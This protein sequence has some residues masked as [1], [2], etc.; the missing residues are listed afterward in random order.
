M[1]AGSAL[2]DV[3]DATFAHEVLAESNTR[4]VVVD[5]WAA[6]CGPCRV[7]GPVI[8]RVAAEHGTDVVLARLNTE[9]NP[10]TALAYRIESIPAV[11]A[12][13]HGRVIA[14]FAGAAPEPQVRAFFQ[15]L[16]PSPADRAASEAREFLR[17]GDIAAAEATFRAALGLQSANPDAIVGLAAIL[18]DRG[19]TGAAEELLERVPVDRRAKALKHRLFLDRFAAD[20]RDEDLQAEAAAHPMD[21]RARYRWG[22]ML[23][24]RQE[25]S[26]A[27]D[28][29]LESVRLDRSFADGA[30]RKAALAVFDILG[31]ESPRTRDYQRRL[32]S[33]LF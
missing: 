30:A 8:E 31:L 20:H 1:T 4:P 5:F 2:R 17:A 6:W 25:H 21:P 29:L 22:V 16:V 19:E 13:R 9:E 14:E 33:L 23:A 28:E 10:K 18:A 15:K 24:A 11:K 3:T 27:L 32:S 7:L 26:L 12:F